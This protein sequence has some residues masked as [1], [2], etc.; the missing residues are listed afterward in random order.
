MCVHLFSAHG[1]AELKKVFGPVIAQLATDWL[2][3]PVL[4]W[5]L[6]RPADWHNIVCESSGLLGQQY[7]QHRPAQRPTGWGSTAVVLQPDWY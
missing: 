6:L 3:G 5:C 7:S 1:P 4:Y 2:A